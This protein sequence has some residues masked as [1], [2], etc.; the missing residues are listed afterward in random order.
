MKGVLTHKTLIVDEVSVD[1]FGGFELR[2]RNGMKLQVNPMSSS[3]DPVNGYW[4]SS[5]RETKT[6]TISL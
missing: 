4:R 6:R 2:F 5:F 3:R 1:D